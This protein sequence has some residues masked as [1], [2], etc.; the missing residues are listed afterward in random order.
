M[1]RDLSGSSSD[2]GLRPIPVR[3]YATRNTANASPVTR[4]N[5]LTA[6]RMLGPD[7]GESEENHGYPMNRSKVAALRSSRGRAR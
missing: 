6:D 1:T 2:E 3:T 4:H 7:Q 5:H